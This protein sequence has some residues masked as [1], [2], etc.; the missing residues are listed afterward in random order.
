M[1]ILD[2]WSRGNPWISGAAPRVGAANRSRHRAFG[3]YDSDLFVAAGPGLSRFQRARAMYRRGDVYLERHWRGF[4]D[5]QSLFAA[6][7]RTILRA[8]FLFAV[9]L[10]LAA[11]YL[12]AIF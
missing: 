6:Q 4:L 8:D 9:S 7:R 12:R 2:R 1:G 11:V 5:A 10:A 3:D